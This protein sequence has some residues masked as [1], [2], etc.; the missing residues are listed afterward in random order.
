M[1]TKDKLAEYIRYNGDMDGWCRSTRQSDITDDDWRQIDT[2]L[3][4]IT[5]IRRG[6]AA[7][8]F[9]KDHNQMVQE[10]IDCDETYTA[11]VTY[12][13]KSEKN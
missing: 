2:I 10:N 13:K 4:A 3:S 9:K 11:L 8:S 7:E 6:L 12:E 5:V 1:I